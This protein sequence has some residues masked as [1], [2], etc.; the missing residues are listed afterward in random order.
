MAWYM[1]RVCLSL[2]QAGS[3]LRERIESW[4]EYLW[5]AKSTSA[6]RGSDETAVPVILHPTVRARTTAPLML[7]AIDSLGL[8]SQ[9]EG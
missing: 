8:H 6:Q 4:T 9:H 2:P 5:I 3:A 1:P 7:R